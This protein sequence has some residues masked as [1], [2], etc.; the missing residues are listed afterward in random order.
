MVLNKNKITFSDFPRNNVD[1][2]NL[3][4]HVNQHINNAGHQNFT[5]MVSVQL[6]LNIL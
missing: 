2:R 1:S 3:I 6:L 4:N 5:K